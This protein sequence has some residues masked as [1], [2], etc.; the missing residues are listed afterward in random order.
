M[1]VHMSLEEQVD[2]DFSRAR[3]KA[4]LGRIGARLRR[5][6]V[7]SR[8]LCFDE[9]RPHPGAVAR[10]HRGMRT[11]PVG[12]IGGSVGRC[13]QFDRGFMPARASVEE[14]WKRIDRALH[15]GEDLPPVE[16][17]KMGDAYFVLDG[18]HR[19]SVARYHGVEW[20]DAEVTEFGA[21]S[22]RWTREQRG[23]CK[24]D[25]ESLSDGRSRDHSHSRGRRSRSGRIL[26]H[27]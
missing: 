20:I 3:R 25:G 14:R 9:V 5:D 18:H 4:L 1:I 6:A 21:G 23:A 16:L 22:S 12:Q 26:L 27:R 17:Y 10:I 11:V 8:L 24:G 15:R 19:V 2:A 7:S 13:S